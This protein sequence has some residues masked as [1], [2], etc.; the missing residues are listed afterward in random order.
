MAANKMACPECGSSRFSIKQELVVERATVVDL[1]AGT[2]QARYGRAR[3]P[4]SKGLWACDTCGRPASDGP[5]LDIGAEGA[6]FATNREAR[7]ERRIAIKIA[8]ADMDVPEV[9]VRP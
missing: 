2:G 8:I 9:F 1:V 3:G 4:A 6:S 7:G 5:R